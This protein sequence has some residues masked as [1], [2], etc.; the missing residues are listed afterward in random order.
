MLDDL[1]LKL[2]ITEI[3]DMAAGVKALWDRP[4]FDKNRVGIYGTSY[5]GYASLMAI[6][7][8]P[9]VFAAASSSSPPTDWRNYDTIYTERYMWIPQENK[10]GYDAGSTNTYAANLKGAL[11]LYYGTADNNVHPNNSMQMIRGAP[12]GAESTSSSRSARTRGTPA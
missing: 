11:L 6:V 1:Y 9:D 2:G 5:G 8:Y 4:Y 3:D 10:D 7:R 12:G